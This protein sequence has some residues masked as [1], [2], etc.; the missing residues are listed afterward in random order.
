[1]GIGNHDLCVSIGPKTLKIY[2]QPGSGSYPD[3][4]RLASGIEWATTS[5]SPDAL[6]PHPPTAKGR[7]VRPAW[8]TRPWPTQEEVGGSPTAGE[9]KAKQIVIYCAWM[10]ENIKSVVD[11]HC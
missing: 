8:G 9:R 4:A 1:M 6:A 2:R 5:A 11:R 7:V 3:L 10:Q